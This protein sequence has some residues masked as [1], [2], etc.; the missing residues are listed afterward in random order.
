MAL[1][2]FEILINLVGPKIVKMSARFRAAIPLPERLAVTLRFW[3]TGNSYTR[4]Q[5]LFQ[6]YKQ[7]ISQIVP[8]VCQAIVEALMENIQVKIVY[9]K[10]RTVLHIKSMWWN[11]ETQYITN[12]VLLITEL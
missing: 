5:Y 9:W 1:A 10:E 11:T 7:T 12:K 3:A 2:D 6:I 8:K 4:L